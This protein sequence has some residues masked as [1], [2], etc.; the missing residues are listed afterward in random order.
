M[1]P[2]W[3][4]ASGMSPAAEFQCQTSVKN[5]ENHPPHLSLQRKNR[6]WYRCTSFDVLDPAIHV[7]HPASSAKP[8]VRHP[9]RPAPESPRTP[10]DASS[11]R[12]RP[13]RVTE[14]TRSEQLSRLAAQRECDQSVKRA[15]RS[16]ARPSHS[17]QTELPR[18][19][20]PAGS[21]PL[22][23]EAS[24]LIMTR[25]TTPAPRMEACPPAHNAPHPCRRTLGGGGRGPRAVPGEVP[26]PAAGVAGRV[27]RPDPR[28]R[29]AASAHGLVGDDLV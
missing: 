26:A 11:E 16:T 12:C 17:G 24:W 14:K 28:G 18:P 7:E 4:A 15:S 19:V 6:R 29:R 1:T 25:A 10:H 2:T 22:T 21:V 20:A 27:A 23:P 9:S 8:Q 5:P 13:G 3:R